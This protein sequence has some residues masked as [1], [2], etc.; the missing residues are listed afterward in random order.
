MS[1]LLIVDD[2]PSITDMLQVVCQLANVEVRCASN[3]RSALEILEEF[4]P[5]LVLTD[6][7]MP[8]MN[9]CEFVQAIRQSATL[10]HLRVIVMTSVPEAAARQFK[11]ERIVAK[12]IDIDEL[13]QILSEVAI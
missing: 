11:G 2:E 12:P 3:G 5:D 13:L 7:M 8:V 10:Q 6:F 4:T 1:R 9:G